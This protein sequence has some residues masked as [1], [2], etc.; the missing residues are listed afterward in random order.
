MFPDFRPHPDER[1]LSFGLKFSSL[2]C[3][4]TLLSLASCSYLI[5]DDPRPPR[6]N[7]VVGERRTPALNQAVGAAM[8]DPATGSYPENPYGASGAAGMAALPNG[9]PMNTP[10]PPNMPQA[11]PSPPNPGAPIP[12]AAMQPKKSFWQRSKGWIFGDDAEIRKNPIPLGRPLPPGVLNRMAP[13]AGN[14]QFAMGSS[15]KDYP[16][17]ENVGDVHPATTASRDKLQQAV[18][19]LKID[20]QRAAATRDALTQEATSEPTLMQEY[21][22]GK[23]PTSPQATSAAPDTRPV[24]TPVMSAPLE[25]IT[26]KAPPV[27]EEVIDFSTQAPT[28]MEEE[29]AA[30]SPPAAPPPT[31][32]IVR[33][34]QSETFE[35]RE[36][37]PANNKRGYLPDSR[38][39]TTNTN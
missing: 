13:A 33:G 12:Q 26:L 9:G 22:Q 27:V 7:A 25:P 16:K 17:L 1:T 8:P 21:Q 36:P 32:N 31:V 37:A 30:E 3:A 15:G 28:L 39:E 34:V 23:L 5:P 35:L 6:Y 10:Q 19:A 11:M 24:P 2:G 29:L 4:I 38:Y 20:E 18:G 14:T